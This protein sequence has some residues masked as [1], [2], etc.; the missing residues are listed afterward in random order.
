MV[1]VETVEV[2]T[3]VEVVTVDEVEI[4]IVEVEEMVKLPDEET[5][6]EIEAEVKI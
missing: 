4:E 1:L 6:I 2:V 3:E 5:A